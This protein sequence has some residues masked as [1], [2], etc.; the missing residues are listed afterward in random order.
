M[1]AKVSRRDIKA[2]CSGL[3]TLAQSISALCK[4][5]RRL[6]GEERMQRMRQEGG[7]KA[8]IR[9]TKATKEIYHDDAVQAMHSK[10]LSACWILATC[11]S[12]HNPEILFCNMM[13]VVMESRTRR[14]PLN[15]KVLDS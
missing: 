10:T 1:G 4:F 14:A 15:L 8:F 11:T 2:I 5:I 6:L 9:E 13:E 12:K 7:A 3:S